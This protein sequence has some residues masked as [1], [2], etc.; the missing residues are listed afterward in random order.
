MS[1]PEIGSIGV[2]PIDYLP[3]PAAYNRLM[4]SFLLMPAAWNNLLII[5][6]LLSSDRCSS[7]HNYSHIKTYFKSTSYQMKIAIAPA[8]F[9]HYGEDGSHVR[10]V[11]L[12]TVPTRPIQ[13]I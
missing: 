6:V 1:R 10:R 5:K 8:N 11:P 7:I 4:Q 2:G 13:W 12:A 3:Y 9:M